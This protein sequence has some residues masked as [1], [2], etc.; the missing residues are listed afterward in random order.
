MHRFYI[1]YGHSYYSFHSF[2]IK[3]NPKSK[4]LI[5]TRTAEYFSAL[6]RWYWNEVLPLRLQWALC[7]FVSRFIHFPRRSVWR[8]VSALFSET[9]S[10]VKAHFLGGGDSCQETLSDPGASAIRLPPPTPPR[11]PPSCMFTLGHQGDHA[12]AGDR[13]SVLLGGGRLC[14]NIDKWDQPCLS[15][16][17]LAK[18]WLC[19][20][21]QVFSVFLRGPQGHRWLVSCHSGIFS[22]LGSWARCVLHTRRR[23]AGSRCPGLDINLRRRFFAE[24][25]LSACFSCQLP[26]LQ[27]RA[28]K[29]SAEE[30]KQRCVTV[31]TFTLW[32]IF[33]LIVRRKIRAVSWKTKSTIISSAGHPRFLWEARWWEAEG[34]RRRHCTLKRTH[35]HNQWAGSIQKYFLSCDM[36]NTQREPRQTERILTA[37]YARGFNSR[38]MAHDQAAWPLVFLDSVCLYKNNEIYGRDE[39]V[40]CRWPRS[41]ISW[42][43]AFTLKA[44]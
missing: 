14:L 8:N 23:G 25:F 42:P 19:S 2:F 33:I 10:A 3:K 29:H 28:G 21:I 1:F 40:P 13:P 37:S 5:L 7:S 36:Q 39:E 24:A 17:A 4:N 31:F 9:E 16:R 15:I 12:Q 18:H 27:C 43:N 22:P 11:S 30:M 38:H 6:T 20:C 44:T 26:Y 41:S 34:T 35:L 32:F